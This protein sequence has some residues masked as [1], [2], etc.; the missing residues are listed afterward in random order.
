MLNRL[1]IIVHN[2]VL[3]TQKMILFSIVICSLIFK[4]IQSGMIL[5][6]Y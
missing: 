6:N 1:K 2:I 4:P 3:Y 5:S